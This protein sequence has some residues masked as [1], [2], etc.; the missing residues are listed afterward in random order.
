MN[1]L[2][3]QS[4]KLPIRGHQGLEYKMGLETERDPVG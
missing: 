3:E 4:L 1:A 2:V